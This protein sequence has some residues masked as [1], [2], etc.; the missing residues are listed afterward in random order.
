MGKPEKSDPLKDIKSSRG[1]ELKGKK[2][3]LCV[4]GSVASIEVP[5]LVRELMRHGAEVNVVMSEAAEKLVR[6]ETLEWA[7]GNPVVRKLTGR[8][9]H[10]RLAGQ[11]KGQADLVLIAP[12]TA[13]TISKMALGIDDTP[14]TT[15]ASMALGGGIPLVICPAAHEP[16]YRNP[17]VEANVLT[18]KQRGAEIVGPR[19]EEGKAKMSSV[20]EIVRSVIRKFTPQDL[21]GKRVLVTGGPTVEF[22]D[23]VRVLTNLSSGKMGLSLANEA[24]R[25]GAEVCYIFGGDRFPPDQIRSTHVRTTEEMR[26]AVVEELGSGR[27]DVFVSA[28][29]PADFAP[30]SRR[31]R[32]LPTREGEITLVLKP[33]PKI[34]MEVRKRWPKVYIA[35]FKAETTGSKK[36]LVAKTME[37][38]DRVGADLVVGNDVGGG[39]TIGKDTSSVVILGRK[40]VELSERPKERI[41]GAILDA[42]AAGLKWA[43]PARR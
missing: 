22:I 41:A 20:D 30:L 12:C 39:R 24:W 27:Y 31:Q 11:W 29:A 19:Y 16:M 1:D 21:K 9:E 38:R 26:N 32:K 15:V 23:P 13:N 42:I 10:V 8:T 17:A 5:S 14:V 28:A 35:A 6:P 3:V 2:L 25:R 43:R 33:T 34:I 7:T 4:T 18:L 40:A 37:F 36:E